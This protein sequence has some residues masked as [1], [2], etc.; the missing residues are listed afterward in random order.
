MRKFYLFLFIL[1][2]AIPLWSAEKP[3]HGLALYGPQDLKYRKG[4]PYKHANVRA[5]KGG[6]LTLSSL[7]SFT[8]LNPFTLKG[9]AAPGLG[10]VFETLV[11]GSAD[12]DEAFS[13]YGLLA[14][15][16]TLPKDRMSITYHLNKKA[17]FS[18]GEPLTADDV[19][20]SFNLIKDP[21]Y[22]P[23][24]K[25]Y[26]A[27]VLKVEK[28][29]DH[30]VTFHF[31]KFNQELPLIMGQ[32]S[33][34]PK[35]IYGIPGKKFGKDFDNMIPV[36]SGPYIVKAFDYGKYISY[37]YTPDY[38]GLD[39]T[40]N[41]GRYNFDDIIFKIFLDP[42]TE[43]EAIKGGLIDARQ[44]N[45]SK[46]WA[47]EYKGEYVKKNY[48]KR[49]EFKHNRVSGMQCYVFNLR[50]P[51]FQD[52]NI[53]KAIS[54]VFDFDYMNKN[55]F[56]GQYKRQVC[57]FD[58]NREMMSR[59]PAIGR[60]RDLLYG[61]QNKYNKPGKD[62][63]PDDAIEVGP[64]N[65]GDYP[66]QLPIEQ[67]IKQANKLLS[68]MGWRY[69]KNTGARQKNGKVLKFT[70]LISSQTWVRIVNPFIESLKKIGVKAD[71]RLV[72]PAEYAAAVESFNFDMIVGVFGQ[73]MSPGN[74][75][76]DFWASKAADTKGSSNVIGIKN[77]AIDEL[78]KELIN[79]DSRKS[80]VGHVRALD[81][82]LCANF[83]V[84]PHWF[85]DY[86]RAI[87]W[88]RI[89]GP[90]RYASKSGFTANVLNWWWYDPHKAVRLDDAMKEGIPFR[91]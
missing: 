72:Q 50:N 5:P 15:K 21:E 13:Q 29:D 62:Y 1:L 55:L 64:Y 27:D 20:F 54:A 65:I 63:V 45:I 31:K 82:I 17:K 46:D 32:L 2:Y 3:A 24:Y 41:K 51:I 44:V 10:M 30:T 69:D 52:I 35:H 12:E 22:A 42:I 49:E 74:E 39:I 57:Y 43:R 37:R 11:D 79:A 6:T 14:E 81:R 87:Y 23:F 86:D 40:A 25:A 36:G 66:K 8:K 34:L 78:I 38:W 71:Y 68:Y 67:K 75:Q 91:E 7:G 18:D 80:L 16:I 88:N 61:L 53:R 59:G 77:P 73:S 48:M 70:I 83:Y 89:S 33:I 58:N 84:I 60:V 76:R 90:K 28:I 56:Y 9:V 85:I 4:Q 19:V 47:L 26:F